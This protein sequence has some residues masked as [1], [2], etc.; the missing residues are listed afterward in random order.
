[1]LD[2]AG[3]WVAIVTPFEHTPDTR[4]EPPVDHAALRRLVQ[5]LRAAEVSGLVA[6]GSTGEAAALSDDE[7]DAVLA[8]VLDAAEGLP[9]IAG[10]AGNHVGHLHERLQ[11]LN[12]LPLHAVLSPAPYYV[13]PSQAGLVRHFQDLADRSL[14]PVVLYDIPYRTGVALDLA[15]I[16]ALSA[17]PNIVGIKDCGGSADKTQRLIAQGHLQVLAG[18]DTQIFTHLALGGAGAITAAAQVAPQAFMQLYRAMQAGHWHDA[19]AWHHRLAPLVRA[20]FVEPNP[21]VIKALLAEQGWCSPTLRAP[22]LSASPEATR[23]AS[24]LRAELDRRGA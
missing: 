21:A 19:R 13:R 20:L 3:I 11:H 16:E 4:I 17:H 1:M 5:H 18:E 7:Q 14:A 9:V 12:T 2:L 23:R 24:A 22:L 8:T 6:L 15:T 10:L